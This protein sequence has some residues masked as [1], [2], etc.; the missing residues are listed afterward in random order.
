MYGGK[1]RRRADDSGFVSGSGR[2]NMVK[3]ASAGYAAYGTAGAEAK[4]VRVRKALRSYF[5]K[6]LAGSGTLLNLADLQDAAELAEISCNFNSRAFC[7]IC[8]QLINEEYPS[9]DTLSLA[10]NSILNL[11]QIM[12]AAEEYHVSSQIRNLDLSRNKVHSLQELRCLRPFNLAELLLRENP[13]ASHRDY[14]NQVVKALPT[15]DILDQDNVVALK[16]SM[17]SQ[18]PKPADTFHF[19]EGTSET[20]AAFCQ[21]FF[22]ALDAQQYDSALM[23]AY[24]ANATLSVTC[25][26]GFEVGYGARAREITKSIQE[27]N[28]NLLISRNREAPEATLAAGRF[29]ALSLL[30]DKVYGGIRTKHDVGSFQ[31]DAVLLAEASPPIISVTIHGVCEFCVPT[32]ANPGATTGCRRSF[33][34]NMVLAPGGNTPEWPARLISDMLHIRSD[35]ASFPVYRAQAAGPTP[36]D[37]EEARQKAL[38]QAFSSA[39][40]LVPQY[41]HMCMEAAGWDTEKARALLEQRRAGLPPDAW[42][43]RGRK[44]W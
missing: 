38:T 36:P 33:D 24:D 16:D 4:Q 9:V 30:R 44:Q 40:R 29:Q 1:G 23:N 12:E 5:R 6:R 19:G 43:S 14:R 13:V 2:R 37:A 3:A 32:A 18:L 10:G 25:P 22:S 7:G 15:I 27:A 17:K 28:H 11:G 26:R 39:T 35:A 42:Q 34:R 8:F 20:V 41:A 31:G 21:L